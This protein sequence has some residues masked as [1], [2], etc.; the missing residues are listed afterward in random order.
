MSIWQKFPNLT[1]TELRT[2]TAVTCQELLTTEDGQSALPSDSL[3]IS[4]A[5]AAKEIAELVGVDASDE[6]REALEDE[7]TSRDVCLKILDEVR[8]TPLL[9]QRVAA[10]YDATQ[11]LMSVE[12][13]LL[14]GALVILTI[15]IKHIRWNESGTD[16]E[17]FE[18]SDSI[19]KF[20]STLALKF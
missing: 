15:K 16:I 6:L 12:V 9:A 4:P 17:F 20:I 19:K 7:D 3:E 18:S 14:V 2:L 10:A 13:L 1:R 5:R 11:N 8:R